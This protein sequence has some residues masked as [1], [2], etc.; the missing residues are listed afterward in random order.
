MNTRNSVKRGKGSSFSR[1]RSSSSS[2]NNISIELTEN[3][4]S[5]A[6]V[7]HSPLNRA[8]FT[9]SARTDLPTEEPLV[10][11]SSD[12]PVDKSHSVLGIENSSFHNAGLL[13]FG[14]FDLGVDQ[15]PTSQHNIN[16]YS[17][18][19][20]A[21]NRTM[22]PSQNS[23]MASG[24]N[25]AQLAHNSEHQNVNM[26]SSLDTL[27]ALIEQT[28]K[29]TQ[30]EFR[31]EL[32]S[33]KQSI[34]QMNI[35]PGF[36]NQNVP[37]RGA[38]EATSREHL[39]IEPNVKLEKW[40]I[41]YGGNG[42]VSDFLFKVET[43]CMRTGCT[44]SHLLANFHVLLTGRAEEWYWMY[45]KRNREEISFPSL[46]HA[47]TKEFGHLESDHEILLKIS[48]RKQQQ[49]ETY[50]D[51][52]S[53]IVTM[54]LRLRNP[55][56]D[57][58]LMDIIKRNLNSGLRFLLFSTGA[59]DLDEF[60]DQARR[61]E[62]VIWESKFPIAVTGKPENGRSGCRGHSSITPNPESLNFKCYNNIYENTAF[63]ETTC[64]QIG[65]QADLTIQDRHQQNKGENFHKL[66]PEQSLILEKT[67]FEFPAF[68][69]IGLGCTSLLE[70][71]I[72]TGDAVPI[73]SKHYP[74]SPPRQ[75]EAYAEIERLLRLGVIEESNSPWCSPAVLVR[76]PGKV[77]LCID[78][79]K[80]NA[81][82][83]KDSYPLP[84]INGLLSRL[85]DTFFISGIDLKDAFLQIRLTETSKE[86]TAFAIP[87]KPLYQYKVMPFG[88]CNGPQTMSRLMDK[89]IPSR[90]REN[91]FVYL[92]DLLVCSHDF[93]S[94]IKLLSQVASCLKRANL[95]INIGKSKFCQ[96]EIR[97]L[98]YIVG[99]GC[100][101]VDPE[102]VE[103]IKNFP[104]PKSP[105]QIRRFVGM[106][107]WYRHFIS[108]F[109]DLA[110]PLTDCLKK[111]NKGFVL[112]EHAKISF[113][114]LKS[115]L[116]TAPILSQPN[117][118]KEFIIQ[119]D[120]SRVGVGG[121]LFQYDDEGKEHPIAFVSQKLNKA[122]RN[123]TVTELECLAAII[124]VNKFR[125]YVEGLPFRIITDH[126]SLKWL[127]SQKDLSGRLARWSLKLQ[128]YD[129]SIEHRK[130]SLNVVPDCLSR[131]NVDQISFNNNSHELDLE[132]PEFECPEYSNLRET[133][134]AN[135]DSLPDIYISDNIIL[136]RTGFRQGIEEEEQS[137]WRVWVPKPL[138][139]TVIKLA[140]NS[141]DAC[142]GGLTKTL[143]RI[144][145]KYFWPTML[146]DVKL[147]L[148]SCDIC[149]KIKSSNQIS[150]PEMG[151]QFVSN[152]AFER[153]YCD[154]LGPYPFTK[155][156]NS[157]IFICI[158]HL[159]K[160]VFLKAL[161]SATSASVIRYFES[162]IF[163]TF[164]VPR[165]IHSD[166]GK[167]FVSKE[168]KDFFHSYD[169]RHIKTGFY[170]PHS[171]ASE[172]CNREIITKVRFFLM[173]HRD[174]KNWDRFIPQILTILRSDFHSSIQCSPYF[175][176]FGQNMVQHGSSYKILDKIGCSSGEDLTISTHIDRLTKIREK[177]K[178]NLDLAH[179]KSA[180]T[181]NLRSRNIQFQKGQIVY[182][183][184]HL[185]SSAPKNINKR[186]LPK[187]VK[188]KIRS[189]VGNNLYDIEDMNGKYVGKFHATDIKK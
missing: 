45:L 5:R 86:K 145:A 151:K 20:S 142:H 78:S 130:G 114:K 104:Y 157:V 16:L 63:Y 170:A 179:I 22:N 37:F 19:P 4:S 71:D 1:G 176:T 113:E 39:S 41:S 150:R 77:R 141:D 147:F 10:G 161:R 26:A 106:A 29:N 89:V 154:F 9:Q 110:G 59:R 38:P 139:D 126:S 101:K 6:R 50:D 18:Q 80:L 162:E 21:L 34:A 32:S 91:V 148:G 97:Y 84:H 156:Q 103:V 109:A 73:K 159:T 62:K 98:G 85:K 42:S 69:K 181:Y 189:R 95:T 132:S 76:K 60:R 177:L 3:T 70:H 15:D 8:S 115:A 48:L 56:P 187:F 137:L 121:V 7:L 88:L 55:L 166:N 66:S 33:V 47:L 116:S 28:M 165:C 153:I 182:R 53:S 92:D 83:K 163:P 17:A 112:S 155:L 188:C 133:M 67:I 160:F 105:K 108:N 135:K 58:T 117:F 140:H 180:K 169:I 24:S 43:L 174:H 35:T 184:N 136:K 46:R 13:D 82:T 74:M 61:A 152:R 158:D 51:F 131:L 123:Y 125:P 49:K 25:T 172:R 102:K 30:E 178:E 27:F 168:I 64:R 127:M 124:C 57:T 119:C 120:A 79:R 167:Q 185:L 186:F 164:G 107:N 171:N 11:A 2:R 134:L 122:Q 100:L 183:K 12:D 99:N 94:H 129:F 31:R 146:K 138:T 149:K 175:A 128:R 90:L 87:G 144:R 23:N 36:S 54:N 14:N 40:K 111:T 44:D 72:D 93:Q 173:E 75:E 81:V 65:V 143:F 118:S 68:E 96:R 52:H